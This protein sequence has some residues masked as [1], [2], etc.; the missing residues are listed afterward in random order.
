[1]EPELEPEFEHKCALPQEL[2]ISS[3]TTMLLPLEIKSIAATKSHM[4]LEDD[5]FCKI[6]FYK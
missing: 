4:T 5:I 1:M 6:L 2:Q 3:L